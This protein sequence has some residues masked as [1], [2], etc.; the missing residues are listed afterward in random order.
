VLE[1][2]LQVILLLPLLADVVE[3]HHDARD[4]VEIAAKAQRANQARAVV[5]GFHPR[6]FPQA[7]TVSPCFAATWQ[8]IA[9]WA[10]RFGVWWFYLVTA[11]EQPDV[12]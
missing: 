10:E 6:C 7:K 2:L 4:D 11:M 5:R 1:T 3:R 8:N 12:R 9:R